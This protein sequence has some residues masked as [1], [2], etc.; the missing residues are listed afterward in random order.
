MDVIKIIELH[1][2]GLTNRQIAKEM[3]SHHN[4]ISYH[5]KKLGL[6]CN[7]WRG[8]RLNIVDGEN[9]KCSRCGKISS[10]Q[11][12]PINAINLPVSF[13]GK[14]WCNCRTRNR[15]RWLAMKRECYVERISMR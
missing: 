11:D 9:A 5:L 4:S 12:W 15:R 13:I 10:L 6:N 8:V 2:N 14:I 3:N 7:G 1:K